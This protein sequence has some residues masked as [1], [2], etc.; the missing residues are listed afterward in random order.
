MDDMRATIGA[1]LLYKG[2]SVNST[3][4]KHLKEVRELLVNAKRRSQG[5][6][7]GVEGKNKVLSKGVRLAMAYSGDAA[8][9]MRDDPDTHYFVPRRA[10]RSGWITCAFL[11]GRPI[12]TWR[13]NSLTTFLTPR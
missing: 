8:C 10:A 13:R 7:S 11:P 2:Y 6:A 9:G 12:V 3:D 1:A 5:F 4:A